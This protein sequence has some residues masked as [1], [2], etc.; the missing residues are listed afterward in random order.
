MACKKTNQKKYLPALFSFCPPPH[1]LSVH[2]FDLRK[3]KKGKLGSLA[4]RAETAAP[5]SEVAHPV[6]EGGGGKE[7]S[8]SP[9]CLHCVP[10][11]LPYRLI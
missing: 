10:L 7:G 6:G 9:K 2:L 5:P 11:G 8:I 4:G 3:K 1:S